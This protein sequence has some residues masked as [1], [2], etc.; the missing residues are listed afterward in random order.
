MRTTALRSS[1]GL[2][3]LVALAVGGCG[4]VDLDDAEPAPNLGV[5]RSALTPLVVEAEAAVGAGSVEA[6]A[7]ASGGQA[8]LFAGGG[9]AE[10]ASTSITTTGSVNQ[11][12]L[13][14]RG[15]LCAP[16]LG[17]LVDGQYVKTARF[18]SA[19]WTDLTFNLPAILAAGPHTVGFHHRGPGACAL[20]V[21]KATFLVNPPPETLVIEAES[22]AGAGAVKA[23]AT[24][25][26]GQVRVMIERNTSAT[27]SFTTSGPIAS[28]S[29]RVHGSVC[30]YVPGLRV[31]VDGQD[32][33]VTTV[34]QAAWTDLA[35]NVPALP[36]GVHQLELHYPN[37]P[38]GC[39]LTIDK[40]TIVTQ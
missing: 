2:V 24:A 21:D 20:R 37:G 15:G 12:T 31:R 8:R 4:E 26:G 3:L 9:A 1:A 5:V 23:D 11:V 30:W 35:L 7:T 10:I 28:G 29:V 6:D 25:S 36:P 17:L 40:T 18:T 34:P 16:N 14:A 13:R 19:A 22:A 32:V 38:S 33:L 27:G 39:P